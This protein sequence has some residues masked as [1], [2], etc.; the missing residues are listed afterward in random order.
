MEFLFKFI[1]E[2]EG[3]LGGVEAGPAVGLDLDEVGASE[4]ENNINMST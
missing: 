3:Q 4:K 1:E 2:K